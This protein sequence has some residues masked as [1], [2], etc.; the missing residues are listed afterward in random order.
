MS[1]IIPRYPSL[2]SPGM[3]TKGQQFS[4]TKYI[5]RFSLPLFGLGKCTD[6]RKCKCMQMNLVIDTFVF[7]SQ[8][9]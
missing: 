3:T 1:Y 7:L 4:E 2:W 5:Y 6:L 9:F 8:I